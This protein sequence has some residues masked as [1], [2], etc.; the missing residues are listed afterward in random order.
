MNLN[1]A[2][3]ISLTYVYALSGYEWNYNGEA[4][5]QILTDCEMGV[6]SSEKF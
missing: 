1:G 3:I 5:I 4:C 6:F 2:C